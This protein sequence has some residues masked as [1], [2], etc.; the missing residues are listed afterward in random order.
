VGVFLWVNHTVWSDGKIAKQCVVSLTMVQ[1]VR[2][3]LLTAHKINEL[4]Y[5]QGEDGKTYDTKNIG[6]TKALQ[7]AYPELVAEVVKRARKGYVPE[8][9]AGQK[10]MEEELLMR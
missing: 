3:E 2:Q 1:N 8:D 10:N 7:E 9:E 5:R 6:T 4:S